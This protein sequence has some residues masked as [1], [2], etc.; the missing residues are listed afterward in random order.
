MNSPALMTKE[1]EL[2]QYN[3]L[4]YGRPGCGLDN[5]SNSK[6]QEALIRSVR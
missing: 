5:N 4:L 6:P 2:Q 1:N 3:S